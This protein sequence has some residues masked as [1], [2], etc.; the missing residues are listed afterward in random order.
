MT[1]NEYGAVAPPMYKPD[2]VP[3]SIQ[4]LIEVLSTLSEEA[5]KFI[6]VYAH[7]DDY[8]WCPVTRSTVEFNHH[9]TRLEITG[10]YCVRDR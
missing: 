1:P 3:L 9:E 2:N 6:M 5:R 10:D 4:D 8:G 7:D